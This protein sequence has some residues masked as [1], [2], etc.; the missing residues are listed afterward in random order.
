VAAA[1]RARARYPVSPW[2]WQPTLPD[3]IVPDDLVLSESVQQVSAP[4]Y[5]QVFVRGERQGVAAT[6]RRTGSA[7][8]V[9]APQVVDALITHADG[10][11]ERGGR[12]Q[13][14]SN[15]RRQEFS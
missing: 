14:F 5:D 7:G 3:V 4:V 11:R 1:L 8:A 2:A 6:V 13:P 15:K 10:A 9:D 12:C